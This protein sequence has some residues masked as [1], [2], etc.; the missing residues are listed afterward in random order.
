MTIYLF[1]LVAYISTLRHLA[2]KPA[3][4]LSM[5]QAYPTSAEGAV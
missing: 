1:L 2:T 5:L 3:G 4:S